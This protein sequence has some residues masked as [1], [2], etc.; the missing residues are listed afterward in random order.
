MQSLEHEQGPILT[1][2]I[3]MSVPNKVQFW[4]DRDCMDVAPD[5]NHLFFTWNNRQASYVSHVW[6]FPHLLILDLGVWTI[7]VPGS[8]TSYIGSPISIIGTDGVPCDRWTN[9][10][11]RRIGP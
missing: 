2:A 9:F 3:F 7:P 10:P 6:Q 11:T 1:D 8:Y 4:F 5:Y